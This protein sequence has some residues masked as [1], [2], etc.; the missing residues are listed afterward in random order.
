ML[1]PAAAWLVL[2]CDMPFVDRELLS[3]L[4]EGR[5]SAK[6][7]TAFAASD[8]LPEPLCAIYEPTAF[9]ALWKTVEEDDSSLR[10]V[11]LETGIRLLWPDKPAM[12]RNFNLPEERYEAM[13]ELARGA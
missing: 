9:P 3:A 12:L 1:H 10:R 13:R 6:D 2:A 5:D 7:A 8:G 4:V 11:L